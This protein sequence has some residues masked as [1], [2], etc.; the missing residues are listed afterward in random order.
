MTAVVPLGKAPK[1]CL[2]VCLQRAGHSDSGRHSLPV[3][4]NFVE[5][6][7][8]WRSDVIQLGVR[9]RKRLA[10]ESLKL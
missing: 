2:R 1:I 6:H 4:R 10:T 8:C 5:S 7:D 9:H 3:F